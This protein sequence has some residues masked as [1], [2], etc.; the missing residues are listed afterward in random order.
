MIWSCVDLHVL[1]LRRSHAMVPERLILELD[2]ELLA[3]G[4]LGIS[5]VEE[6]LAILGPRGAAKLHPA[7]GVGRVRAAG[8]IADVVRD[9]VRS[10][11][12]LAVGEPPPVG[13]R[14]KSGER[15]G[16]VGR[17]LVGIQNELLRAVER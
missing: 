12:T 2:L 4:R 13:R 5:R 1:R 8:E 16:T 14:R 6:S 9:P 3:L 11:L 10:A 15:D 7:D 17:E